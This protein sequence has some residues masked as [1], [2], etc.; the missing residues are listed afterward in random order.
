MS[1]RTSKAARRKGYRSGLEVRIAEDLE[2]R[3]YEF[4]YEPGKIPFTQPAKT[5]RFTPDFILPNGI[6]IEAKGRFVTA[7]R[8]KFLMVRASHPDLDIRFCF[9]NPN[10]RISKTSKTT[11]ARWCQY[12]G[13]LWAGPEVPEEW[14]KEKPNK[15][16]IET[17]KELGL[18]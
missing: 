17:L 4:A 8:Q 6:V 10:S 14:L 7:D 2:A 18:I 12:K 15:Q 1:Y 16:S 3:G 11:Y 5:R 9:S 13:F